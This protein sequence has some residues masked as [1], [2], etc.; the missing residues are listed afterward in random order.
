[1]SIDDAEKGTLLHIG[2]LSKSEEKIN[3]LT[4]KAEDLL[5]EKERLES[6]AENA[7]AAVLAADEASS[8]ALLAMAIAM[9][10]Q[11]AKELVDNERDER[12]RMT[13]VE[14]VAK[15]A[16]RDRKRAEKEA[17]EESQRAAKVIERDRKRAE[18]LEEEAQRAEKASAKASELDAKWTAEVDASIESMLDG[19]VSF[20]KI[21]SKLGNGLSTNDI[22]HRW[23][24]ELKKSSGITKPPVQPGFPSRITWT[25]DV[26][27]T[28][29]RMRTD[30]NSFAKI[31]SELGN[32]LST[33]AIQN[34]WNRHLKDKLL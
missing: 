30:G 8:A 33:N 2:H 13:S 14:C 17:E 23:Y 3:D 20:S 4:E 22:K 28:I 10:A 24:R 12:A 34:R 27:A 5:L 6:I 11:T 15:I 25:A 9:E 7:I 21:A 19:G 32:G 1:M 31:A 29:A 26:D 18:K 16:E